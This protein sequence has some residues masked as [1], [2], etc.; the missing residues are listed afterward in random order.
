MPAGESNPKAIV[1]NIILIGLWTPQLQHS[2]DLY[3]ARYAAAKNLESQ[4]ARIN[5]N[6]ISGISWFTK[7]R[8]YLNARSR[9][10]AR[11]PERSSREHT[12]IGSIIDRDFAVDD[13][14]FH[15]HGHD[16]RLFIG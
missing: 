7:F 12:V 4:R 3:L 15:S 2:S 11:L 6:L 13:H 10:S 16:F 9:H 1:N 5:R 14:E 8:C